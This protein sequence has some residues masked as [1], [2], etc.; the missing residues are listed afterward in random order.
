MTQ[1]VVVDLI[2]INEKKKVH[3]VAGWQSPITSWCLN[4]FHRLL[5]Y[6]AVGAAGNEPILPPLTCT[7]LPLWST[8]LREAGQKRAGGGRIS[9]GSAEWTDPSTSSRPQ[10]YWK[11]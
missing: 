7:A 5:F 3:P 8:R 10:L 6:T 11:P 9:V 1:N 4:N 2:K